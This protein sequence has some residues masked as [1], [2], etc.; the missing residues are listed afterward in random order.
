MAH[1]NAITKEAM[2]ENIK[3]NTLPQ[4]FGQCFLPYLPSLRQK[5]R[6]FSFFK[7][8]YVHGVR[9]QKDTTTHDKICVVAKCFRSQRKT[10]DSHCVNLVVG[11]SAISDAHC[12]CIAGY[13]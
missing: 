9:I 7:E 2:A 13:V 6:G 10:A 8:H 11:S 12:S 4:R 5:Q 3:I 1:S